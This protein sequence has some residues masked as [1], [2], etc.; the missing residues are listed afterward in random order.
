MTVVNITAVKAVERVSLIQM[1]PAAK[2]KAGIRKGA[3]IEFSLF[4]IKKVLQFLTSAGM[5]KAVQS[6]LFYLPDTLS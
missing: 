2:D 1:I 6:L 4:S 5:T 3:F